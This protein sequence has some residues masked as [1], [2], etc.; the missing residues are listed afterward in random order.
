[1]DGHRRHAAVYAV[2]AV[3]S[4]QK[5]R[6]RLARA[7]DAGELGDPVRLDAVLEE[8]LDDGARDGVVP[9]ARAERRIQTFVS[10]ELVEQGVGL[11][12]FGRRVGGGGSR[13]RHD[14]LPFRSPSR[15]PST[16]VIAS[17][18]SPL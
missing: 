15:T 5:V 3:R 13:C 7:S 14:A 16:M 9:A 1:P 17:M 4:V 18:G 11:A 12:G 6:R 10:L 8:G 2:E